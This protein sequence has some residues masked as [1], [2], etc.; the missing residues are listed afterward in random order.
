MRGQHAKSNAKGRSRRR[1]PL[2]E[3]YPLF[4]LSL[5]ARVCCVVMCNFGAYSMETMNSVPSNPPTAAFDRFRH[6][7]NDPTEDDPP[8]EKIEAALQLLRKKKPSRISSRPS[9]AGS[10]AATTPP[11]SGNGSRLRSSRNKGLMPSASRPTTAQ[12]TEAHAAPIRGLVGECLRTA[13]CRCTVCMSGYQMLDATP[14]ARR[15]PDALNSPLHMPSSEYEVKE[16][17]IREL[18]PKGPAARADSRLSVAKA[19]TAERSEVRCRL[20]AHFASAASAPSEVADPPPEPRA[21]TTWMPLPLHSS[22]LTEKLRLPLRHAWLGGESQN[23]SRPALLPAALTQVSSAGGGV[24]S[25]YEDAETVAWASDE[26]FDEDV[27]R[28][29]SVDNDGAGKASASEEEDD[30]QVHLSLA[31][32]REQIKRAAQQVREAERGASSER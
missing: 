29:S 11:G 10:V 32:L 14:A 28:P 22:Q 6:Y 26:D 30:V 13:A 18:E 15:T 17:A 5:P 1:P 23:L 4:P 8:R 19:A 27:L 24:R 21:L 16:R 3:L 31:E 2:P 12:T 20:D 9:T 7:R 25:S